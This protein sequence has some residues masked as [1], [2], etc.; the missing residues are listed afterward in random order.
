M[1]F[2][3]LKKTVEGIDYRN[4]KVLASLR[5]VPD[6]PWF[7]VAKIDKSEVFKGLN[8]RALFIITVIILLI[9]T[10]GLS[11][12]HL[13]KKE[14]AD[15]Y[16]REYGAKEALSALTLRYEAI[17]LSQY[18][19]QEKMLFMLKA[20]RDDGTERSAFWHGGAVFLRI[21]MEML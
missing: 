2:R 17:L 15:F 9:A 6:T 5:T 21:Q 1:L 14:T 12:L 13:W 20:G 8:E 7:L 11:I 16:E 4:I 3:E 10:S 19:T 18:S